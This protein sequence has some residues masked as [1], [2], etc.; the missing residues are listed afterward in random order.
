[1]SHPVILI[2]DDD[3]TVCARLSR[4]LTEKGY[5]AVSCG[6]VAEALRFLRHAQDLP[7]MVLMDATVSDTD[8]TRFRNA[9]SADARLRDIDVQVFGTSDGPGARPRNTGR[10]ALRTSSVEQAAKLVESHCGRHT[11][12]PSS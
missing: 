6:N 1:M 5:W 2:V 3:P 8:G 11:G 7:C 10:S 4:L 12:P 9:L